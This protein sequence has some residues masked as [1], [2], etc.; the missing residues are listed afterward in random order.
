MAATLV[1]FI[2]SGAAS[3]FL[4]L[5][6]KNSSASRQN[7]KKKEKSESAGSTST[8]D[9]EAFPGDEKKT[10]APRKKKQAIACTSQDCAAGREALKQK[11][12]KKAIDYFKLGLNNN[13]YC[14]EAY[15]GI[16]RAKLELNQN[17]NAM[18]AARHVL[19]LDPDRSEAHLIL[20]QCYANKQQFGKAQDE[21]SQAVEKN[22]K[23]GEA[24]L[25]RAKMAYISSLQDPESAPADVESD[26][27][28][29]IELAPSA[30]AYEALGV[31]LGSRKK[32][33]E[34][35]DAFS[36]SIAIEPTYNAYLHRSAAYSYLK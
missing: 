9:V 7:K 36:Q 31:Y 18:E 8:K 12:Y 30:D 23:N 5:S 1:F 29:A 14:A 24:Y 15:L 35:I 6:D 2:G 34:A 16:A 4:T 21:A 33:K 19:A 28:K 3:L 22:P 26:M 13:S 25:M 27:N 17:R 20:A 32:V 11:Q 10:S